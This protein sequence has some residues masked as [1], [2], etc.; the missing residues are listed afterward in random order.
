MANNC[1][2]GHYFQAVIDD[3][4]GIYGYYCVDCGAPLSAD[5]GARI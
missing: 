1:R 5:D 2:A 3:E 4:T